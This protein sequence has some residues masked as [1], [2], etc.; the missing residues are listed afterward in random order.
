MNNWKQGS[1][2]LFLETITFVRRVRGE[3]WRI[4]VNAGT[5]ESRKIN[6]EPCFLGIHFDSVK[7]VR[8]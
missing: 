8:V 6:R 4:L 2:I 5:D 3:R 7:D 1:D